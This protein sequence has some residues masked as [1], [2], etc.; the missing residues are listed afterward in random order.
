MRVEREGF[1]DQW[2][3]SASLPA[4]SSCIYQKIAACVKSAAAGAAYVKASTGM[5]TGGAT[6][7]DV[8]PMR[9]VVG[10]ASGVKAAGAVRSREDAEEM[11]AAGA[12]RIG[13]S[14]GG[15]NHF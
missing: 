2:P 10:D 9:A 11:L 8:A 13:T 15:A 14:G 1:L 4:E 7:E 3:V 6:V 12:D 5:S